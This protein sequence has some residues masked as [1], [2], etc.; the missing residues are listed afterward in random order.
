SLKSKQRGLTMISWMVVLVFF[1]FIAVML[2]NILPVYMTD[3]TVATVMENLPDDDTAKRTSAKNLR[4]LVHKR[5]TINSVYSIK[6][7]Y[8]KV[9]KG[10]GENIVLIEYEPRGTLVGS[11]DYIVS[12]K[13]EARIKTR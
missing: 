2:M 12:F 9:K 4:S 8:I 3:A 6:P 1:I 11:L 13:H 5:L 7:E 10:R